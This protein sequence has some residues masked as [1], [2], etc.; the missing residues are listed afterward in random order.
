MTR[1]SGIGRRPF[2][3]D[4][5]E[6]GRAGISVT[7]AANY[8]EFALPN[9]RYLIR[10]TLAG[11]EARLKPLGFVRVHRTRLV[12]VMRVIAIETR[13]NGD[14]VA[15]MDTGEMIAGSR[16]FRDAVAA[17]KGTGN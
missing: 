9:A 14:F 17:I 10:G 4:D 2:A 13:S 8:V 12:N 15:K 3:S 11:E 5:R 7:S 16:R 6:H 1:K